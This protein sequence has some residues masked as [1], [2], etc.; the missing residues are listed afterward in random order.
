MTFSSQRSI[1]WQQLILLTLCIEISS[2]S[3]RHSRSRPR[4]N[5]ARTPLITSLNI[6]ASFWPSFIMLHPKPSHCACSTYH[7]TFS[8]VDWILLI[9]HR[10]TFILGELEAGALVTTGSTVNLNSLVKCTRTM[11]ISHRMHNE[12]I[13]Q[14]LSSIY[15]LLSLHVRINKV[16]G[17]AH[18]NSTTFQTSQLSIFSRF[19]ESIV[20]EI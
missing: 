17:A 18:L 1:A 9:S 5:H 3:T 14:T 7:Q 19:S 4:R 20:L 16:Y 13:S 11:H 10:F 6:D 2:A 8:I 15:N 12:Q